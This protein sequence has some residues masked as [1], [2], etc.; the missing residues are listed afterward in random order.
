MRFQ[1]RRQ[2]IN[3]QSTTKFMTRV[4]SLAGRYRFRF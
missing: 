3:D 2:I 4:E 1:I